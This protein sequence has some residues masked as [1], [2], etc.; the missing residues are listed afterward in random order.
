[1]QMYW[2]HK[3]SQISLLDTLSILLA[4]FSHH[5]S[6]SIVRKSESFYTLQK[7]YRYRIRILMKSWVETLLLKC[8][9]L[10][11]VFICRHI[12]DAISN[13]MNKNTICYTRDYDDSY[14][15][16]DVISTNKEFINR[17]PDKAPC[18]T[19]IRRLNE[20]CNQLISNDAD[21]CAH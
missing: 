20:R 7:T 11:F 17:S 14:N 18:C 19:C 6:S 3:W 1:M 4:S 9:T 8:N 13:F 12:L 2:Y 10:L 16:V 21:M 15:L 5:F